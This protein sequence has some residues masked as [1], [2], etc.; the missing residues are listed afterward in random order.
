MNKNKFIERIVPKNFLQSTKWLK[1]KS[2]QTFVYNAQIEGKLKNNGVCFSG[3]LY[4]RRRIEFLL[5]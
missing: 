1:K 2:L 5:F 3:F 4:I